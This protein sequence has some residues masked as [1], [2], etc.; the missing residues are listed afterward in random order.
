MPSSPLPS[1]PNLEQLRKQAK[2]LLR[3]YR[4]EDPS[5][6]LRF[7]KSLPGLADTS[8]EKLTDL[9]LSLRDAQRVVADEHGF[10]SWTQLKDHI[11]ELSSSQ[12]IEMTIDR[13]RMHPVTGQR[14]LVLKQK[15]ADTYLSIWIGPAEAD[16][17]AL[18]LEGQQILR[19]LTHDLMDS[20]ISDLGAKV[21]RVVVT[22]LKDQTFFAKVIIQKNGITIER[23]SRTSDAI[24][25]AV[26]SDAP[27]FAT[28]NVLD[29]AG[30]AFNPEVSQTWPT[31]LDWQAFSLDDL[32]K[33]VSTD[34]EKILRLAEEEARRLGCGTVDPLHI[35][36]AVVREA[37]DISAIVLADLGVDLE[38]IQS[39]LECL[40]VRSD[41]AR[42]VQPE[43]SEASLRVLRLAR[44]ESQ[45]MFLGRVETEHLLL[46]LV[47]AND[48]Q[49]T[50]VLRDHGIEIEGVRMAVIKAMSEW[51]I[52][53]PTST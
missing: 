52:A 4:A 41:S 48:D 21:T 19:P 9:S 51:K 33:M 42:D 38:A 22:D 14:V 44:M 11:D 12:M 8:D 16:S 3:A 15:Q 30:A 1:R 5:A 47:L 28:P 35:L 40:S 25:L 43:W 13:I 20:M 45:M 49:T 6:Q 17:I 32:P 26:R 7:R 36:L 27:I 24:A 18:K 46:G 50:Q 2:D 29:Q 37:K 31:A 10:D 23:D 39:S 34:A 53:S